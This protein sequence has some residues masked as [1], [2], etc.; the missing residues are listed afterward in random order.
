MRK[1]IVECDIYDMVHE[2]EVKVR[3]LYVMFDHDQ[4]DG[5]SKMK[6]YLEIK[7][8]DMCEGCWNEMLRQRRILYAYGA[9]GFNKYYLK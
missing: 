8:L 6:P 4:D 2:G 1:E 7:T 5:K 9:M 3:G